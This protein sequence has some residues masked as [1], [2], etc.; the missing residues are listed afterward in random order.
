MFGKNLEKNEFLDDKVRSIGFNTQ[1]INE[2]YS[3][4]ASLCTN[5]SFFS[6]D[7]LS[8]EEVA[9]LENEFDALQEDKEMSLFSE[10]ELFDEEEE[11]RTCKKCGKNPCT[12]SNNKKSKLKEDSNMALNSIFNDLFDDTNNP[13]MEV[14]AG[15][16]AGTTTN[17]KDGVA[18]VNDEFA[19]TQAQTS[20]KSKKRGKL[21]S[22]W[23]LF[24]D[25]NPKDGVEGPDGKGL[26][27]ADH[28]I[29]NGDRAAD[30]TDY[31]GETSL[32]S[33]WDLFSEQKLG[34]DADPVGDEVTDG[35]SESR[36]GK[37]KGKLRSEWDIFAKDGDEDPAPAASEEDGDDD[38]DAEA[39]VTA[40]GEAALFDIECGLF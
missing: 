10:K 33:E 21:H 39:E 19:G 15:D 25:E 24:A 3:D 18:G 12:C 28:S 36:K 1:L 26:P 27:E 35:E 17:E 38:D 40:A 30:G 4:I 22:E 20:K 8:D 13:E 37:K 31:D 5:G 32:G 6:E 9:K 7:S 29:E 16:A 34:D 11:I 2:E 23:D 14:T